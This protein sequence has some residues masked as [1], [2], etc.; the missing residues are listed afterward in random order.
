MKTYEKIKRSLEKRRHENV[1]CLPAF[2]V[3]NGAWKTSA[4]QT[5]EIYFM[6][7]SGLVNLEADF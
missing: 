1:F 4:L 5:E 7:L 2:R 6:S 3:I